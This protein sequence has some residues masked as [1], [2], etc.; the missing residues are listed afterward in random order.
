M[1]TFKYI[2]S[3]LV[4]SLLTFSCLF[5]YAQG[6]DGA[7]KL[8]EIKVGFF[9]EKLDL[10]STEAEKFWPVYNEYSKAKV[11]LRDKF[12][13]S[14]DAD[15][16]VDQKEEEASLLKSY[17]E[18]FKEILPNEKV[19]LLHKAESELKKKILEEIKKRNAETK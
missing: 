2:R 9:T 14:D 6:D 7:E 1:S 15:A 11:N 12:K 5:S 18:K 4:I 17:N 8:N 19:S 10:T 16:M 13:G 3:F